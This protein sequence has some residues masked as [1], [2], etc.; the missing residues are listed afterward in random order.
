MRSRAEERGEAAVGA[1]VVVPVHQIF[2]A[3]GE[4]STVAPMVGLIQSN[5]ALQTLVRV[6]REMFFGEIWSCKNFCNESFVCRLIILK[7]EKKKIVCT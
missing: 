5:T 7:N 1:G 4:V 6:M 3:G 2:V